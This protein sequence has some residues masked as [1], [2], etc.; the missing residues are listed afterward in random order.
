MRPDC[1]AG[2]RAKCDIWHKMPIH[3]VNMNPI[4]TFR[5]NTA[6]FFSKIGKIGRKD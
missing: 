6:N 1:G 2:R 4:G 5:F 3:D